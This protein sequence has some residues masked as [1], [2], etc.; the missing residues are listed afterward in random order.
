MDTGRAPLTGKRRRSQPP[1]L[2]R[3]SL[4]DRDLSQGHGKGARTHKQKQTY[5]MNEMVPFDASKTYII[6]SVFIDLTENSNDVSRAE[7]ELRLWRQAAKLVTASLRSSCF[8]HRLPR[9][10]SR[11][12]CSRYCA[13]DLLFRATGRTGRKPTCAPGHRASATPGGTA[14]APAKVP[15]TPFPA[16]APGSCYVPP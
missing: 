10:C 1:F 8:S 4:R 2:H 5:K 16:G 12:L 6:K 11:F 13:V 15:H 9:S 7:R 3:T 14:Q